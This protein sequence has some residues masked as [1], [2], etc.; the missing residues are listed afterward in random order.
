MSDGLGMTRAQ[1]DRAGFLDF[2]VGGAEI[3][4]SLKTP[5]QVTDNPVLKRADVTR[6]VYVNASAPARQAFLRVVEVLHQFGR[7]LSDSV[8]SLL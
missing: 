1:S 4:D 6:Y 8:R 7:V 2:V 3:T 5:F